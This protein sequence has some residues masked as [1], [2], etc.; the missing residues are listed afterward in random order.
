VGPGDLSLTSGNRWKA[1]LEH[2]PIQLNDVYNSWLNW[3][4][5]TSSVTSRITT[6]EKC[7]WTERWDNVWLKFNF[8]CHVPNN[9]FL[10]EIIKHTTN[11][12]FK[13]YPEYGDESD[14]VRP[15]KTSAS[16]RVKD[17]EGAWMIQY[18]T[19]L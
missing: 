11:L 3:C 16:L 5:G 13:K 7:Y 9:K 8:L 1:N 2:L 19:W 12:N 15:Q 10:V 4:R 14:V 18:H 17:L 6:V